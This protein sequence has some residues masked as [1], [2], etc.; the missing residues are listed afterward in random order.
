MRSVIDENSD[1]L[2]AKSKW[3]FIF[4]LVVVSLVS[5]IASLIYIMTSTVDLSRTDIKLKSM[6][7]TLEQRLKNAP[8]I[9]IEELFDKKI[10]PPFA[11][12]EPG[13]FLNIADINGTFMFSFGDNIELP[14][15][16][17]LGFRNITLYEIDENQEIKNEELY[18]VFSRELKIPYLNQPILIISGRSLDEFLND[19]ARKRVSVFITMLVALVSSWF[20]GKLLSSQ[21]LKP[22]KQ[23]YEKL[24]RFSID[25]SHELKTPITIMKTS[26]DI[27]KSKYEMEPDLERKIIL[28]DRTL[29]RMEKLIKQLMLLAKSGSNHLSGMKIEEFDPGIVCEEI[30]EEYQDLYS[31][32]SI[33]VNLIYDEIFKIKTN[34]HIISVITANLLENAIKFSPENSN[35]NIEVRKSHKK[36]FISVEDFGTGIDKDTIKNIFNRFYK[37][38]SSKE[39]S[40][41]GL[42]IVREMLGVI[43]SEIS[44]E[45]E[46]GKGSKFT[47]TINKI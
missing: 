31:K 26:M 4:V 29:N 13:W 32:K 9:T 38:D 2:K 8:K 15:E 41:L 23:S 14:N 25:A 27:I 43:G 19:S 34:R 17:P 47:I 3:T 10:N 46:L 36:A 30:I 42:S 7:D 6:I 40:G 16:I 39:G 21:V 24:R 28:M 11:F 22:I 35:I 37:K 1:F 44:V 20:F 18:R 45:S 12:M 33:T 5:I